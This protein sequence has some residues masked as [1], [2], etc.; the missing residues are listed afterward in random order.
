MSKKEKKI[1][2]ENTFYIRFICA[3]LNKTKNE[4]ASDCIVVF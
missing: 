3:V 2:K 4:E 1:G